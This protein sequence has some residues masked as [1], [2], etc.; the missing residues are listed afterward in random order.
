MLMAGFGLAVMGRML[1]RAGRA[2]SG[3]QMKRGMGVAARERERQ[4][5]DRAAQEE[6]SRDDQ[7]LRKVGQNR[8][9]A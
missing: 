9:P 3:V 4:Q 6:T 7:D 8:I 5:H 2:V 1:V